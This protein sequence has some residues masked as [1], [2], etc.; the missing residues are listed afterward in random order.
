MVRSVEEFQAAKAT[1]LEGFKEP[2][3]Y[4]VYVHNHKKE[5]GSIGQ[6]IGMGDLSRAKTKGRDSYKKEDYISSHIIADNLTAGEAAKIEQHLVRLFANELSN[7]VKFKAK[8]I[9]ELIGFYWNGSEFVWLDE[10]FFENLPNDNL[11]YF[12]KNKKRGR[13]SKVFK[14]MGYTHISYCFNLRAWCHKDGQKSIGL[15]AD[16]AALVFG[17]KK[18]SGFNEVVRGIAH[19]SR[20][21]RYRRRSAYGWS[22]DQKENKKL[23]RY[24]KRLQ[25]EETRRKWQEN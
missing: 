7:I 11:D 20:G 5:D 13:V 4:C 18:N 25:E 12:H 17:N 22:I 24:I 19:K 16:M 21:Y 8:K 15:P 23:Q 2:R 1:A 9:H 3:R 10:A 14:V 6:Y